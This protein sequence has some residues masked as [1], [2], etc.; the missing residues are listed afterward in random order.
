MTYHARLAF[1]INSYIQKEE[2]PHPDSLGKTRRHTVTVAVAVDLCTATL[3]E[4]LCAQTGV[5]V[6]V[7]RSNRR[8]GRQR[9][10]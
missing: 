1:V 9:R 3:L 5:Y 6:S 4:R 8:Q 10:L 7:I 2:I